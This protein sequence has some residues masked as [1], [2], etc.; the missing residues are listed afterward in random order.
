MRIIR[1]L[2]VALIGGISAALGPFGLPPLLAAGFGLGAGVLAC[3]VEAR[4]KRADLRPVI[5][6]TLGAS[7]GALLALLPVL[8]LN[9]SILLAGRSAQFLKIGLPLVGA[10]IGLIT[11]VSKSDVLNLQALGFVGRDKEDVVLE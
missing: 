5:G 2:F 1:I 8:V 6:G 3:L 11:G 4:L 10:Y 7:I 9:D